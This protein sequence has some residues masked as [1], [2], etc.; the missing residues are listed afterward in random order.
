MSRPCRVLVADPH[1]ATRLGV[2]LAL[3]PQDFVVVAEATTRDEAVGAAERL[4]P[5]IC[6][7]DIDLDG[8][9]IAAVREIS[10]RV[11]RSAVVVLT[12]SGRR[13]DLIGA[14]RAGASG[15]L[16]KGMQ[17]RDLARAL[18]RVMAGDPA[19]APTLVAHL[20]EEVRLR[21]RPQRLASAR[22]AEV[23]LTPR[24]AQVLD[25]LA[26]DLSTEDVAV[27]LGIS[28]VTVRR[29]V[30]GLLRKLDAPDRR[31]AVEALLRVG[32]PQRRR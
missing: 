21:D 5:D 32:G 8:G 4:V 1:T 10:E 31:A 2:R 28:P 13:G 6:L 27:R 7:L 14:L 22:G 30:S 15:Y 25:L 26:T 24:E 19:M 12:L 23:R 9:G 18:R 29:H 17:T 11:P 20:V 3:E 16:L